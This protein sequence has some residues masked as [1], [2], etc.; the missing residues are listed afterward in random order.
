[1]R[2]DPDWHRSKAPSSAIQAQF[3]YSFRRRRTMCLHIVR[4]VR[5]IALL[6]TSLLLCSGQ[7]FEPTPRLYRAKPQDVQPWAEQGSFRFIRLDGGQIERWKAERSRVRVNR[8]RE[9]N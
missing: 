2:W 4:V 6:G 7:S 1:M 5:V 8:D 9:I 3:V